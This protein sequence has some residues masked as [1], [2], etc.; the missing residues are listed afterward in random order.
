M[1]LNNKEKLVTGL[2]AAAAIGYSYFPSE[3]GKIANKCRKKE[4][5]KS[6]YLTFDDGPD[7]VHTGNLL[8]LLKRYDIKATFFLVAQ[9]AEENP[10]LVKRMRA[11]GHL[12]GLHS[13]RHKSAMIQTPRYTNM[14][15]EKSLKIMNTLGVKTNYYRPPWG[16]VNLITLKNLKKYSLNKSLWDVMVQDWRKDIT[17]DEIQYKLLKK[18]AAGDIVCLHDGRGENNAPARMIEALKNTIPIWIEDGYK[19]KRIN[20]KE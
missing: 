13:L 8:D 14:E 5:D 3:I 6:I 7:S 15:F 17:V 20:E 4:K 12:I 11:E 1:Q 18:T 10:L 16:H 2:V 19:F 9:F